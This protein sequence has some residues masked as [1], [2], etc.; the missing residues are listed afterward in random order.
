[1]KTRLR[2]ETVKNDKIEFRPNFGR[3]NV[4]KRRQSEPCRLATDGF[5]L[6]FKGGDYAGKRELLARNSKSFLHFLEWNLLRFRHDED[7]PKKLKNHETGEHK[8]DRGRS[9][10]PEK[11][12]EKTGNAS[13]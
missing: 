9:D 3:A 2:R 7:R 5:A 1:M 6:S 8:E 12:R 11:R 4:L 13:V 10:K